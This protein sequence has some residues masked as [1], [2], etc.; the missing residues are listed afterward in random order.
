[1]YLKDGKRIFVRLT[2]PGSSGAR[3][4]VYFEC[5]GKSE[6]LRGW[7]SGPH[8]LIRF[9]FHRGIVRKKKITYR[10]FY[11]HLHI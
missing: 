9:G 10:T 3:G 7:Y 4:C 6:G 11:L 1:M 2:G 8:V 5:I